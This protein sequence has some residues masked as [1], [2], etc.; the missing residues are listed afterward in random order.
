MMLYRLL[1]HGRLFDTHA[2]T[3][4]S[5]SAVSSFETT[6]GRTTNKL[7]DYITLMVRLCGYQEFLGFPEITSS[8]RRSVTCRTNMPHLLSMPICIDLANKYYFKRTSSIKRGTWFSS[9]YCSRWLVTFPN[10]VVTTLK[11]H[12]NVLAKESAR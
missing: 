5:C 7:S 2:A 6:T 4:P 12:L 3:S 9:L 11:P 8:M 10:G 1:G